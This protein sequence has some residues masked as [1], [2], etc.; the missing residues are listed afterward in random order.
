MCSHNMGS[1]FTKKQHAVITKTTTNTGRLYASFPG[2]SAPRSLFRGPIAKKPFSRGKKQF[3][4]GDD[5][6]DGGGGRISQ[7]DP[8]PSHQAQGFHIPFGQPSLRFNQNLRPSLCHCLKQSLKGRNG[9][10]RARETL[11]PKQGGM[12]GSKTMVVESMGLRESLIPQQW[13]SWGRQKHT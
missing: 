9:I 7:P 2:S 8:T 13:G 11:I 3:W 5:D 4:G 12:P 6:G 10:V 1:I